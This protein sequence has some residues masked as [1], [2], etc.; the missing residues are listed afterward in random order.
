[1]SSHERFLYEGEDELESV[2]FD[3]KESLGETTTTGG[4][5]KHRSMDLSGSVFLIA[6]NGHVL[7]LPIPSESP[8]DPLNWANTR[9]LLI[10]AILV[11]YGAVSLFLIQTPGNLYSAFVSDFKE[12]VCPSSVILCPWA[13]QQPLPRLNQKKGV[14]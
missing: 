13:R 10:F 7:N 2:H 12:A 3:D 1:M 5:S 14:P 9:R 8:D 11:S 4:R 6:S